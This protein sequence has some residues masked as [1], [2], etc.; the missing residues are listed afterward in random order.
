M[1]N[2]TAAFEPWPSVVQGY[3]KPE[4]RACITV[5][6]RNEEEGLRH[7]LD[8]FAAQT[9]LDGTPMSSDSYEVILLLNNCTD[10]SAA[11]AQVWCA[12]HPLAMPVHVAECT[13]P[14][15][16]AHVGTARRMLMDTAWHRLQGRVQ[17]TGAILST[18]ADTAVAPD[19]VAQN[20]L[21]LQ[22]ADVVGGTVNLLPE[23]LAALPR[24][25]STLR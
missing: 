13:L 5:P 21:A 2:A 3:A 10:A 12:E 23:H 22:A 11:V 14:P 4:C 19:W 18:D 17:G 16:Q 25:V 1:S 24:A 15:E 20:L 7:C 9:E 8:A 6:A